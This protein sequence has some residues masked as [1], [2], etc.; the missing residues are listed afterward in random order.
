MKRAKQIPHLAVPADVTPLISEIGVL[1]ENARQRIAVSVNAELT[2]L[3]WRLG[4]QSI[5]LF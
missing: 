1:I 3:N 4:I 2:L 5:P